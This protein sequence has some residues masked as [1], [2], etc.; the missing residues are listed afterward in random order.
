MPMG[1]F[2]LLVTLP[3][4]WGG[5]ADR[6]L[7]DAGIGRREATLALTLL[8]ALRWSMGGTALVSAALAGLPV[9]ASLVFPPHL[10]L[11]RAGAL[12]LPLVLAAATLIDVSSLT[13]GPDPSLI[14]PLTI[15]ALS[16]AL[17]TDGTS[18]FF[19]AA[20]GGLVAGILPGSPVPGVEGTFQVVWSS[21]LLGGWMGLAVESGLRATKRL[22]S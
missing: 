9:A 5:F 8:L 21:C 6:P 4:V 16:A 11:R 12:A 14:L 1:S 22:E 15:G 2:L 18:A 13:A 10:R 19:L 3:L 17:T 20:E 7:A